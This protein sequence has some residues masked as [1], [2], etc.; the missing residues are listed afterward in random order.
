MY[1]YK[2][3]KTRDEKELEKRLNEHGARGYRRLWSYVS[4]EFYVA[5]MERQSRD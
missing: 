4:T 2:V 3:I 1:E 5:I